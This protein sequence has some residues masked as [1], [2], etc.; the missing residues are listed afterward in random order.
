MLHPA[1]DTYLPIMLTQK[2]P[3]VPQITHPY[4]T[5]SITKVDSASL[6]TSYEDENQSGVIGNLFNQVTEKI[7]Q[8]TG[9]VPIMSFLYCVKKNLNHFLH[10]VDP[11][12][13]YNCKGQLWSWLL[14]LSI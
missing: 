3:K 14:R 5:W 11:N 7:W 4:D 12:R 8:Q 10:Y 2:L 9:Q 13:Y 6:T 1:P